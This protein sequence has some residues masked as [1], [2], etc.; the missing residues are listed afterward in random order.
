MNLTRG[1]VRE[2]QALAELTPL[3]QAQ[4]AVAGERYD[5]EALPASA[6]L[7]S[8]DDDDEAVL[9][10]LTVVELHDERGDLAYVA[11]TYCV[12]SGTVFAAGGTHVVA[13]VI[14]FGLTCSDPALRAALE[15][16]GF[17]R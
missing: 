13:D 15:A 16:A 9:S 11:W 14:Q 17:G 10:S 1:R 12:D 6:R 5:G 4:L 8:A 3:E 7:G 2:P